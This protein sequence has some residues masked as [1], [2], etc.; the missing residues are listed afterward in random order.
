[1]V[2]GLLSQ[3][4]LYKSIHPCLEKAIDHILKMDLENLSVGKYEID[5]DD[6]FY[7]V[8]EY[9]TKSVT[10]CEPERHRKYTDIQ[11]MVRGTEKFGYAPYKNQQPS[12][13]F[14]SGNDVAFYQVPPQDMDY[15]T[16]SPG[17]FILFFPTDI[18]QPEVF[19]GEPALV[20][21]L[22]VKVNTLLAIRSY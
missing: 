1:M 9:W 14:L 18:H 10:E 15:I 6:I 22:V 3:I 5:G 7:M 11:V 17:R 20:K 16:L 21:K 4:D 8:N 13:G 19:T 2:T 12:T